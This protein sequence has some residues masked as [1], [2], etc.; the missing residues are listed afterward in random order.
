MSSPVTK[1]VLSVLLFLFSIFIV[2]PISL[3]YGLA[4]TGIVG[5]GFG[6][7]FSIVAAI[8]F[9][10]SG[11]S[12]GAGSYPMDALVIFVFF[13]SVCLLLFFVIVSIIVFLVG[14][15]WLEAKTSKYDQQVLSQ[16]R[17]KIS[18]LIQTVAHKMSQRPFDK[19]VEVSGYYVGAISAFSQK[20]LVIDP[21]IVDYLSEN[22]IAAVI[23]HEY[24][25]F[26][27]GRSFCYAFLRRCHLSSDFMSAQIEDET[28]SSLYRKLIRWSLV[29]VPDFFNIRKILKAVFVHIAKITAKFYAISTNQVIKLFRNDFYESELEADKHAVSMTSPAHV[30]GALI[31]LSALQ[32]CQSLDSKISPKE[33]LE[34]WQ[35]ISQKHTV[36]HPSIEYRVDAMGMNIPGDHSSWIESL[37]K[38][39]IYAKIKQ[40]EDTSDV[41]AESET[42]R[43]SLKLMSFSQIVRPSE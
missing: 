3:L 13:I 26:T 38:E 5:A 24:G 8:F 10:I 12:L 28:E 31:R 6:I 15:F 22:E 19:I 32:L 1:S 7:A 16:Q 35:T 20:T 27:E 2:V 30:S 33:F 36:T 17:E 18:E 4:I 42:D 39:E 40:A 11:G 37:M 21:R 23:A 29:L 25:H 43:S 34:R 9:A 14:P 41:G